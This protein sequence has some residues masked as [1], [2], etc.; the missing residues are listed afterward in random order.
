MMRYRQC[1]SCSYWVTRD[2]RFCINCGVYRPFQSGRGQRSAWLVFTT[3]LGGVLGGSVFY[4]PE[5]SL[6]VYGCIAGGATGL[7]WGL[8]LFAEV[9]AILQ[10]R[11]RSPSLQTSELRLAG[12]L[13]EILQTKRQVR[14]LLGRLRAEAST[15][16]GSQLLTVLRKAEGAVNRAVRR[17]TAELAKLELIRWR[18]GLEPLLPQPQPDGGPHASPRERLDEIHRHRQRGHRLLSA[19]RG[20]GLD[21]PELGRHTV[22]QLQRWLAACDRLIERTIAEQAH[23]TLSSIA[24][25]EL[26]PCADPRVEAEL[27]RLDAAG[28]D[29]EL[30]ELEQVQHALDRLQAKEQLDREFDA[31]G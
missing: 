18:N 31:R 23:A 11:R 6:L 26:V 13:A 25:A 16:A 22:Q 19:W 24:A 2:E 3:M 21:T 28:G 9:S 29:L 5:S 15:V 14:D 10:G 4:R 7:A 8:G 20:A 12:R 1:R 30:D 17:Y 27:H